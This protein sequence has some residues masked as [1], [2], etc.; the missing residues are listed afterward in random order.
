[1]YETLGPDR[2]GSRDQILE[3]VVCHSTAPKRLTVS[4]QLGRQSKAVD[5]GE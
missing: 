3:G 5:D 2:S 4:L 1:M